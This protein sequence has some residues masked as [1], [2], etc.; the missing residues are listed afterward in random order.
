MATLRLFA[1]LREAAG[2]ARVE[3]PGETVGEVL[4]LASAQFG[5]RFADALTRARV[6]VNGEEAGRDRS[7]RPGDEVA[8]LPPVSGGAVPGAADLTVPVLPIGLIVVLILADLAAGGALWAAAIVLLAATWVMDVAATASLRGRDLT[9]VPALVT[10]VASLAG[11][12]LL[13]SAGFGVSVLA[14]VVLTLSWGVASEGARLVTTMA[15]ALA[16][17]LVAGAATAGLLLVRSEFVQG[18]EAAGV[19]LAVVAAAVVAGLLAERF[20][21]LPLADPFTATVLAAVAAALVA[22]AVWDLD[23][24]A[25]LIAGPALAM[26]LLAGRGLGSMLRTGEVVLLDRAPGLLPLLDG[27]MLAASLY[28]PILTL[29]G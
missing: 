19:Y 24:V 21:R 20:P 18:P 27:A 6:W 8:L 3:L 5:R 26:G 17:S 10:V 2:A 16:V 11:V 12:H 22:A 9:P 1:G 23:L 4:D 14:A 7:V 28:L 25:F 15:A 29:V 13:G